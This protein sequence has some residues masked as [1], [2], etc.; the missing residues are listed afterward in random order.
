MIVSINQPA[1]LPWC[2]YFH[3][4]ANSDIHVVLDHVQFE[5]NSFTN[6]NKIRTRDGWSMLTVPVQTKGKFK[7]LEINTL[8][9]A[10]NSNWAKKHKASLILNYR[11]APYFGKYFPFLESVYDKSWNKF[12]E[13]VNAMNAYLLKCLDIH[14]DV[15]YS[16]HLNVG[17]QKSDCVLNLCRELGATTYLSGSLGRDYLEIDKFDQNNI[18]VLYHDYKHPSYDQ[19]YNHF[20]PNMSVIDLLFNHGEKSLEI[21]NSSMKQDYRSELQRIG[22]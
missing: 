13:L 3:R 8:N 20:E 2:G 12:D 7:A 18:S 19:L 15:R 22:K 1:Y 21:L 17:G 4:I 5:K 14:V 10:Q 16:S 9:I 11:K 6:R